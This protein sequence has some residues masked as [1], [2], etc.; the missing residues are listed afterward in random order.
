MLDVWDP[1]AALSL[2]QGELLIMFWVD[3]LQ[4]TRTVIQRQNYRKLNSKV[5]IF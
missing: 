4:L 3:R 1:S 5:S 2:S